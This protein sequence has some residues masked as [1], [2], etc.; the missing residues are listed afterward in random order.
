MRTL[1]PVCCAAGPC[2]LQGTSVR[3]ACCWCCGGRD[4][5]PPCSQQCVQTGCRRVSQPSPRS[6][7]HMLWLRKASLMRPTRNPCVAGTP[8]SPC[9][10][11]QSWRRPRAAVLPGERLSHPLASPRTSL[12]GYAQA[13]NETKTIQTLTPPVI[14]CLTSPKTF[15]VCSVTSSD[16]T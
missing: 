13:Q 3:T 5:V 6:E 10:Y 9:E 14:T 16:F 11:S 15:T 2:W 7:H 8:G 4:L 12:Q 1:H